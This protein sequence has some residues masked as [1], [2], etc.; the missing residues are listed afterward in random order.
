[1]SLI[2]RL[3]N[4][5][6]PRE[7]LVPLYRTIVE[8]GR[9]TQWYARGGVLDS[10]DGRFDMIAAILALTLLRLEREGQSYAGQTALLTELF[11]EDMDGQLRELGIGDVIVGKHIGKMMG[12]LGG[13][14]GAYRVGFADDGDTGKALLRNLYR[15]EP[16]A[17]E[18]GAYTAAR[19][20]EFTA[21]LGSET[22][23]AIIAG[24][25]PELT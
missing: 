6:R 3:F 14:I 17:K 12:A 21:A 19:L 20:E 22:A 11:I 9:D 1:M 7:A 4:R 16:P 24:T 2:A 18:A 5:D 8:R 15:G 13:R 25:L 10:K 23:E